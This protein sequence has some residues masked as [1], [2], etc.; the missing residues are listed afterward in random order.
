MI[1]AAHAGWKGTL[2]GVLEATIE[3]MEDIVPDATGYRRSSPD[4]QSARL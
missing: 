3:A 1:A 2:D 4:D